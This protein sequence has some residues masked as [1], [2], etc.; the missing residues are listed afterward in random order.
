MPKV[1]PSWV[2]ATLTAEPPEKTQMSPESAPA[3]A[4][5]IPGDE[6]LPRVLFRE[7]GTQVTSRQLSLE[8]QT[9]TLSS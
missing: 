5:E 3:A 4:A 8:L 9:M 2:R 7:S 6:S 1:D